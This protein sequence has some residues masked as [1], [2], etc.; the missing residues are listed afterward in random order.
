MQPSSAGPPL[1]RPSDGGGR[2]VAPGRQPQAFTP[3]ARGPGAG[4]QPHS[5]G[6]AGGAA[7]SPSFFHPVLLVHPNAHFSKPQQPP[8]PSLHPRKEA[9]LGPQLTYTRVTTT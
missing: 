5:E 1:N 4:T 6:S 3:R 7:S 2:L 8:L 9:R